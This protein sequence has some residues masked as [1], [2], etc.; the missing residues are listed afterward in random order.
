MTRAAGMRIA[1]M[2]DRAATLLARLRPLLDTAAIVTDPGTLAAHAGD[3]TPYAGAPPVA[4][5]RPADTAGVAHILRHASAVEQPI[6]VQGGRTGL[7]GGARCRSGEVAL[8]LE[9][10]RAIGP[11][12][13]LSR[14]IRVGAGVPLERVQEAARE[15]GL[16]FS[17]DLGARGSATIGGM[18]ATNAGG[19][20]VMR[21]GMMRAHV[22]G[23]DAVMADGTVVSHMSGLI[24]DNAGP[25]VS[26]LLVGSEGIF[27]VVTAAQLWLS[28]APVSE[29]AAMI[30]VDGIEAALDLLAFL[31]DRVG[32]LL[33]GF[34]VIFPEVYAG[35][36][37]CAGVAPP[38]SVGSALY[39]LTDIQGQVAGMDEERFQEALEQAAISGLIADAVVS[40]SGREF[41]AL[42]SLRE[43]A[44]EFILSLGD[45]AGHDIGVPLD[46]MAGF[47]QRTVE[48]IRAIDPAARP[49]VFGHL[50]DGNLHYIVQSPHCDRITPVVLR[51]VA[52]AGGTISAEH[53]IGQDKTRWLALS[54]SPGEI[55]MMRKLKES[56]DPAHI[57]NPDRVLP[58]RGQ[59]DE[60]PDHAAQD[61][62]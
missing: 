61:H 18:I 26:R 2:D 49:L 45:V 38:L 52:E 59:A 22:A 34:E 54:R 57:L 44:S 19:I 4:V 10:L 12:D 39:V 25:D 40:A 27:G 21:H 53:G 58:L 24:K 15:K 5:L 46:R 50:G 41:A 56:L 42:W 48:R 16:Q 30:A 31:R 7:S 36:A 6:V 35:A 9:R 11:V 60:R 51:E 62:Y 28:A 23:I 14:T 17:V 47:L 13:V 37:A 3:T 29:Q 32:D 1:V 43:M 55:A 8:S 33:A 20:R